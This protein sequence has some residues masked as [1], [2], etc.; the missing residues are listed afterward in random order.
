MEQEPGREV[1][2]SAENGPSPMDLLDT[3]AKEATNVL[4][5]L[6]AESTPLED[7]AI[8]ASGARPQQIESIIDPSEVQYQEDMDVFYSP[9]SVNGMRD[10]T[11]TQPLKS[12][13]DQY[14]KHIYT[15]RSTRSMT[16]PTGSSHAEPEFEDRPVTEAAFSTEESDVPQIQAFA[17]LEFDDGEFYM[18]TYSV[19]LGRDLQSARQAVDKTSTPAKRGRPR[20]RKRSASSVDTSHL[21]RKLKREHNRSHPSSVVSERGGIIAVDH[22]DAESLGGYY[23]K[24]PASTS[25]S[26]QQMSRKSS[27]LFAPHHTDYQSLA[28]ASLMGPDALRHDDSSNPPLPSPEA[29]PLIPIHPPATLPTSIDDLAGASDGADNTGSTVGKHKAIS[30]KHVKI[31]FNFEKH[32]FEVHV[33]GRNGAYVDE[34]YCPCGDVRPLTNGSSLQIGNVSV[35]FLLPEVALGETGA[36]RNANSHGLSMSLDSD[37]RSSVDSDSKS[38][39]NGEQAS[40]DEEEDSDTGKTSAQTSPEQK[41]PSKA[42]VKT[43]AMKVGKSS[44]KGSKVEET[45]SAPKRK[46]PG[47]PP[48]NGVMSKREMGLIAKQAR[49]EAK[50]AKKEVNGEPAPGKGKSGKVSNEKPPEVPSIQPNGKRKYTKRKNKVDHI[51]ELQE[52]RESTEHTDSVA[53]EQIVPPKPPKEKKPP[54]PPRSPSPFIDRNSLTEEQ[55]AKP[56]QSY[57]V[58]IHEALSE[59]EKGPMSLNQ[60]YRAIAHK[61]PYFKFVVTTVGWQSSIRHNLLQHEAFEKIEREGKGWMWGLKPGISIEKERKRRPTPPPPQSHPYYPPGHMMQHQYGYYPGMPPPPNGQPPY[62]PQYGPP[63]QGMPPHGLP[64]QYPGYPQ[65]Y[66]PP[67]PRPNGLPLPLLNAATDNSKTYQ[68]PYESKPPAAQQQSSLQ[69]PTTNGQPNSQPAESPYTPTAPSNPQPNQQP[70]Q[71]QAHQT[72]A[73]ASRPPLNM[74]TESRQAVDKFKDVLMSSMPDKAFGE[75]LITSAINRVFGSQQHSGLP[76]RGAGV[77]EDPQESM[78]MN[79]LRTM[80]PSAA[81]K[82]T[83]HEGQKREEGDVKDEDKVQQPPTSGSLTPGGIAKGLIDEEG[84]IRG[85]IEAEAKEESLDASAAPGT[86]AKTE[87]VKAEDRDRDPASA[88]ESADKHGAN[89]ADVEKPATAATLDGA[90]LADSNSGADPGPT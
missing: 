52:T 11:L 20:R 51:P 61:Y 59:S 70:P 17:K 32:L 57:V 43:Q 84:T 15:P 79:A 81:P 48:K 69:Q 27:M 39:R 87:S 80:I 1:R 9:N 36:E 13:L 18:N 34:E 71:S 86:P 83:D 46:G 10:N 53:P 55:L 77:A 33:F 73:T 21:P 41:V 28:M 76:G 3:P 26:S 64:Q 8:D 88:V 78:V 49:E 74:T 54:K 45:A 6:Y 85:G 89:A 82:K 14:Q 72:P 25:S 23:S 31:A 29:C 62:H 38:H 58:L 90:Q 22:S 16:K 56:A 2:D 4:R 44:K 12:G 67:P 24:E 63:A 60:I 42:K 50:A 5:K 68:S 47:R 7:M 75:L 65:G 19:E 37:D 30:R 66:Y 35:K 40:E